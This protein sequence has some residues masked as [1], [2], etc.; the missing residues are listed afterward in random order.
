MDDPVCRSTREQL[1]DRAMDPDNGCFPRSAIKNVFKTNDCL[2]RV[3]LCDCRF[4]RA[5]FKVDPLVN[6]DN[7]RQTFDPKEL[8]DKYAT[9]YALLIFSYRPGLIRSFQRHQRWLNGTDFFTADSLRFLIDEDVNGK[10]SIIDDVLRN[11]YRF[12][13]RAIDR[14]R[15]PLALDSREIL[16]IR[17]DKQQKGKGSFGEVYGFEFAYPEYRGQGLRD[18]SRFARKI[19]KHDTAGLEEWFNLLHFDRLQHPHLMSALA[20]FRHGDRFSIVFEEAELTLHAYLESDDLLY[21]HE[22]LW[23]QVLGLADGLAYLHGKSGTVIAYHGDLKPANILIV[24][25]VMKIA[26]FGLLQVCYKSITSPVES[27]SSE[28][29]AIASTRPYAGPYNP[30]RKSLMDVWSFGAILSEISTFD[31]EGKDG[32]QRYRHSRFDDSQKEGYKDFCFHHEGQLKPSVTQK[33]NNLQ[34]LVRSSRQQE[35]SEHVSPFQQH[36][37][38]QKFFDL[39][40]QMLSDHHADCPTSEYATGALEGMHRQAMQETAQGASRRGDIWDDVKKGRV[41]GSPPEPNCRL[42]FLEKPSNPK[43]GLLLYDG[44]EGRSLLVKCVLYDYNDVDMCIFQ[45]PFMRLHQERPSFDPEYT[46]SNSKLRS[47]KATL[48]QWDGRL[49]AFEFDDL[50]DLLILQAAMTKQYVF[51][52]DSRS[53]ILRSLSIPDHGILLSGRRRFA[54]ELGRAVIQLWSEKP[55]REDQ[56]LWPVRIANPRMHIAVICRSEKK[57]LLIKVS[58]KSTAE[59]AGVKSGTLTLKNIQHYEVPIEN[60]LPMHIPD[61]D[62]GYI[63]HRKVHL[64]FDEPAGKFV[65][66]SSL[67]YL[68]NSH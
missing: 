56:I 29:D 45:E 12:Q 34:A 60:G 68:C 9:V 49:Y 10:K 11:Q 27:W 57:L 19:F 17:Q 35:H 63:Q 65:S 43:C 3:Y 53:F 36:F 46:D 6:L 23:S 8:L 28:I 47:L 41:P 54:V 13:L 22:E 30:N 38:Q 48:H 58:S 7:R 2:R 61:V 16:P 39:L 21:N 24:N 42:Q 66:P 50:R 1:I 62:A 26:D 20:A 33:L 55:L 44:Q 5:D 52:L 37:F 32:L 40:R 25:R 51:N 15:E 59:P 64:E 4:C 18:I 14:S 67:V 31:L